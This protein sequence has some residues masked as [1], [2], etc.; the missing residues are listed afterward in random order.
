MTDVIIHSQELDDADFF[1]IK[2]NISHIFF[3]LLFEY[4]FIN[5]FT[6]QK[7]IFDLKKG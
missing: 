3:L 6:S 2:I 1:Y 4:E 5:N 7:Y